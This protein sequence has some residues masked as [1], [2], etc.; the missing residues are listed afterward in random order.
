MSVRALNEVAA[1]RDQGGARR[2]EGRPVSSEEVRKTEKQGYLDLLV[3]AIPTEPL[4]LYTFLI[5]GIVATLDPGSDQRL[6]MRWVIFG[7]TAVFIFVWM[8]GAYLRLPGDQKRKLPWPEVTSAVIAFGAWGL[9][10]PESPLAAELSGS[11]QTVW[12]FII[13]AAGVAIVGLLT[14]SMKRPVSS[15]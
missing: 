14:G 7:V 3:A 10:M 4:A 13:I 2:I 5:A 8:V 15:S 12:T 11:D 9:V 6:T 1:Q